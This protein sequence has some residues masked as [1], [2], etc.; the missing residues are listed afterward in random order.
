[1]SR[2]FPQT[3]VKTNLNPAFSD[4]SEDDWFYDTVMKAARSGL[5]TGVDNEHFLPNNPISRQDSAVLM[6]RYLEANEYLF[7]PTLHW[8]GFYDQ[9][10]IQE[11]AIHAV[12]RLYSN[13]IMLGYDDGW[14]LPNNHITRAE[15]AALANRVYNLFYKAL[16]LDDYYDKLDGST[17][18]EP[19]SAAIMARQLEL[20]HFRAYE[21]IS[22]NKTDAAIKNVIEG[23]K[24]LALVTYPS[25]EN[26]AYAK[27]KGVELA[28]LPIVNDA[29]VFLVNA[30][31]PVESL[32]IQ[33]VKDI[34][35]GKITNWNQVGGNDME[36][37]PLQRNATSGSQ[38][39]MLDFMGDTKISVPFVDAN[40]V[41]AMGQL[42]EK[43]E[44]EPSAIGYSY[45]YYA[46][47]MYMTKSKLI[48]LEGCNPSETTV[49][50]GT[51]PSN[52]KYY[53]VFRTTEK[54]GSF[55]RNLTEY[56][57]SP[58]GQRIASEN[59][60][61]PLSQSQI[62]PLPKP[63]AGEF[64]KPNVNKPFSLTNIMKRLVVSSTVYYLPEKLLNDYYDVE[65]GYDWVMSYDG[66][67]FAKNVVD[68]YSNLAIGQLPSDEMLKYASEKGVDLEIV[69][70]FEDKL[71]FITNTYNPVTELTSQQLR[72][73]CTL[74][75]K[76]W[77]EVGGYDKRIVM[78]GDDTSQSSLISEPT[79]CLFGFLNISEIYS[80]DSHQDPEFYEDETGYYDTY[81]GYEFYA[82]YKRYPLDYLKLLAI[83]GKNPLSDD[84]PAKVAFYAIM[85]KSEP[86]D[87]FARNMLEFLQSTEGVAVLRE[88]GYIPIK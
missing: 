32:T 35:S 11:Y 63:G 31:N 14:F 45:Y 30:D 70:V 52:T 7:F 64:V 59:G 5:I 62:V 8:W 42:I 44:S 34:Y 54:E 23:K 13:G 58:K 69:P 33:Q 56:I 49:K 26:L 27:S 55:A 82:G 76:N 85:R 87:S 19:L 37:M 39:G 17:V 10:D 47:N 9:T 22:H 15:S 73:I 86:K 21:L 4:V 12:G 78:Y 57:L 67:Q 83:D 46:N 77:S 29:F 2:M 53:A 25:D 74:K 24:D 72:D 84:Y 41:G 28:I 60:Y 38:S 80:Y 18:T 71:I 88:L 61:V 3:P 40:I 79:K 66:E 43:V 36:I 6:V 68:G 48:A 75:I 65:Y 20:V 51:Y 1:M 50:N 16:S 81:L